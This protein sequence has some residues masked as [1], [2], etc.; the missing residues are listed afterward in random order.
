MLELAPLAETI[1]AS[2]TVFGVPYPW[3]ASMSDEVIAVALWD[4]GRRWIGRHYDDRLQEYA[5]VLQPD[6]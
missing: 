2:P 6:A 1:T 5:D 4:L 3:G